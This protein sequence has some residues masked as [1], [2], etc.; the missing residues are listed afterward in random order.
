[1]CVSTRALFCL[2]SNLVCSQIIFIVIFIS[3]LVFFFS[4]QIMVIFLHEVLF[5]NLQQICEVGTICCQSFCFLCIIYCHTDSGYM[6]MAISQPEL[7]I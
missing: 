2:L 5:E 7:W 6:K 4:V 3:I 1:M